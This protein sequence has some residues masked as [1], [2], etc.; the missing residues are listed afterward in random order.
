MLKKKQIE[1]GA[2]KA[3]SLGNPYLKQ[4]THFYVGMKSQYIYN[5]GVY[6]EEE[7]NSIYFST[8]FS[9]IKNGYKDRSVGYYDKWYRYNRADEGRAYDIGVQLALKEK[10]CPVEFH[11]IECN[12]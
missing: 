6:S 7:L 1:E 9:D 2:L 5:G 4:A 3:L 12:Y 10:K 11:I 8:A